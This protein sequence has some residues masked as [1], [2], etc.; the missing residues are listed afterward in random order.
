MTDYSVTI[1]RHKVR[2][3]IRG[4]MVEVSPE[5]AIELSRVIEIAGRMTKA[6][7][8]KD[9]ARAQRKITKPHHRGERT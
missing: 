9:Q 6:Q 4:V 1:A 3:E 5:L 2:I 7:Q 8:H